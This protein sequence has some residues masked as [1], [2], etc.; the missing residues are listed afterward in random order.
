MAW[1]GVITNAGTALLDQ[2]ALG[3]TLKITAAAT[4][5]GTVAVA[6]LTRQTALVSQKQT[7]SIVSSQKLAAGIKVKLQITAPN[8]GYTLNQYG[9]WARLGTGAQTLLALFQKEEGVVIPSAAETPDFAYTL[10]ALL[11]ISNDGELEVTIDASALVTQRTMESYVEEVT[12]EFS[13]HLTD[14]ANP[15]QVTKTQVG[16]GNVPNVATNN[17]TPTYTEASSPANLT[18][19]E[20]L[21]AAFG[22]IARAVRSLIAHLADTTAH[23]T[24][25]ERTAWNGKQGAL[26]FDST[27]TAGSTNPV[28][29]GGVKTYADM[30]YPLT[31]GTLNGNVTVQRDG[32]TPLLTL[33]APEKADV[34]RSKTTLAK[35]ASA[36]VDYGTQLADYV[37][38]DGTTANQHTVLRILSATASLADRLV[39]IDY[40]A[41]GNYVQY[42]LYGEHNPPGMGSV[43][44]LTAALAGK[45]DKET[46]KGLSTNDFTAAEKTKLAGIAAGAQVNSI[47]GVKGNAETSYRTGNVT[48][49][50][51]NIG[52]AP[53]SHNHDAGDINVGTLNAN[54]LP[55]VPVTKGG[56]GATDALAAITALGG[57]SAASV[58]TEMAS[59]DDIDS[60]TTPGTYVAANGTIAASLQGTPPYTTGG[61]KLYVVRGYQTGVTIQIAQG[62]SVTI[63]CR[64]K[65]SA[66]A[67][68][69]AWQTLALGGHAHGSIRSDGSIGQDTDP[70]A[71]DRLV[72]TDSSDGNLI[73]RGN[74]R[75]DGATTDKALTPKGTWEPFLKNHQDISGKANVNHAHGALSSDGKVGSTS[76]LA[77]VTGTGGALAAE[78]LETAAPEAS[79]VAEAFIASVSQSSKGKLTATKRYASGLI[80]CTTAGATAAKTAVCYGFTPR[81]GDLVPVVLV[82]GN[83][84]Q[85]PITLNIGG[86]GARK[87]AINS[88]AS[89]ASNYELP[90]GVYLV[91]V[92]EGWYYFRT[93]GMIHTDVTGTALS[94]RGT[95]DISHGGTGETT[96]LAAL[97]ALGGLSA[98]DQGTLLATNSSLNTLV[99]PGTYYSPSADRSATITGAPSTTT[100]FRLFVMVGHNA[101]TVIQMANV[102]NHLYIRSTAN[103]GGTWTDWEEFSKVGHV[104]DASAI[105]AGTLAAA[106]LPSATSTTRGAVTLGASGGAAAYSHN[107]NI[108]N[109]TGLQD[110]LDG[111]AATGH[112][113]NYLP[114]SGGTLTGSLTLDPTGASAPQFVLFT[115]N[116]TD[117]P[118]KLL[119]YKNAS[120]SVDYGTQLADFV[121]GDG[122]NTSAKNVRITLRAAAP[123]LDSMLTLSVNQGT[124]GG[125]IAYKIY[126]EHNKPGIGDV[127]GLSARLNDIEAR[128]TALEH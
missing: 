115:A 122:G 22:K 101:Q 9:I 65:T 113:H 50:P 102:N 68:W 18:S 73:K 49:T 85:G 28:T 32:T 99:T 57:L 1:T 27:P 17:Q 104:H 5:T 45:V 106:R 52:A 100:G 86:T 64:V 71:S 90:A 38:G 29:S 40:A 72:I 42:H 69:G 127:S 98:L 37:W 93:D 74:I 126:G 21:S 117:G 55:T 77:L 14:T 62:A 41:G 36:S 63:Y 67:T 110:A 81:N 108:A 4:G 105:T 80:L 56:T 79:G 24:A 35:N 118:G 95:L 114:L 33:N 82:N 59:G 83:T 61:F 116:G 76:G 44:G 121:W 11:T 66:T 97:T 23:I 13:D 109:V 25:A 7:A 16:L 125:T 123:A 58:G 119:L 30:K 107:H 20:K 3:G 87:I 39:L 128:L 92:A 94:I 70:E 88:V 124:G 84:V 112:T 78:S 47:T 89:S 19:G 6:A 91:R 15:H 120:A 10:Y 26:T 75:F 103:Q 31:G 12:A 111:K 46:G 43:T 2:W 54:R 48:L 34:G 53:A 96:A 8:T 60:Y 51:A